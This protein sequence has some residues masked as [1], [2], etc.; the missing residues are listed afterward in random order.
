MEIDIPLS[1]RLSLR[2][3]DFA[4]DGGAYPTARLQK[5]WLLKSGGADLA[6][7]A[8]GF[9]LPVLK[10]GLMTVFPG[11]V[12][13]QTVRQG[14]K[15]L[16]NARFALNRV[17]KI[18]RRGNGSVASGLF[19]VAK[20]SLAMYMVSHP[21]ARGILTAVSN[22]LRRQ[23]GWETTYED[24]GFSTQVTMSYALDEQRRSLAI[25]ADLSQLPPRGIT[26]V[27]LMNEQG[28]HLFDRYRDTGG[29]QLSGNEIGS[30][31]EVRAREATFV[32][33]TQQTAFTVHQVPGARLFRGRELIGSRL[34]WA[35]FGHAFPPSLSKFGCA[36]EI[37]AEA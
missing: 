9:G 16:I 24:A 8:V 3:A 4:L 35:G 10:Q 32:S 37:E 11:Q 21:P 29:T 6:E 18:A 2:I 31:D 27:I 33:S 13:L 19:Y 36:V 14:P 1:R 20:N 17:E 15:W 12:E 34:A 23:F 25:E 28:A 30:W 22:G 5:G 7:E 26:E